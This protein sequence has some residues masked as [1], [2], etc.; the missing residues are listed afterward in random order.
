V[1]LRDFEFQSGVDGA[2][3]LELVLARELGGDDEGGEGL[4]ATP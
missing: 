3:A 1:D 4:A 2:V